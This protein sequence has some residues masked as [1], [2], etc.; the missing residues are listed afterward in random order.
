MT[1]RGEG[2]YVTDEESI[3]VSRLEDFYFNVAECEFG[4]CQI[5]AIHH[6]ADTTLYWGGCGRLFCA[7]HARNY[8]GE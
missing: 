3:V 7:E 2:M 1:D 6:C 4:E 5:P 8:K